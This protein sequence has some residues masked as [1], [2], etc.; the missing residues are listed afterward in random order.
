M[1]VDRY[2]EIQ[3]EEI[4]LTILISI[5]FFLILIFLFK[6]LISLSL[7]KSIKDV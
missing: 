1:I 2:G 4:F 6:L 5:I 3:Q 7:T